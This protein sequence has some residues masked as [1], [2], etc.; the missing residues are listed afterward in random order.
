M[1]N[2]WQPDFKPSALGLPS[3]LG[4]SFTEKDQTID[5]GNQEGNDVFPLW[6]RFEDDRI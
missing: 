5:L 4:L 3:V 2:Q 1:G 6:R